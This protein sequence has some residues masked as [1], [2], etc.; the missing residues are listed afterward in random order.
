M[1]CSGHYKTSICALESF[2]SGSG[3][4][5]ILLLYQPF[6]QFNSVMILVAGF[7]PSCSLNNS[8]GNL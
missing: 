4:V 1:L 7:L 6:L 3:S 8:K 2:I 5:I